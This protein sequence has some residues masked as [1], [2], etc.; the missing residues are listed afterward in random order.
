MF[1]LALTEIVGGEF[2]TADERLYNAIREAFPV[3]R[4][5][6]ETG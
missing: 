3:I 6:G 5:L 2:W 4:W 1:Y